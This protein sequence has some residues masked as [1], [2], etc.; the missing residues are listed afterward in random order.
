MTHLVLLAALLPA[1]EPRPDPK[2]EAELSEEVRAEELEA[3][4]RRLASA[5][6]MGRKGP[7]AARASRL[8]ADH[9][10]NL[11]LEPAFADSY[12]QPIPWLATDAA[13]QEGSVAG[14]N[15]AAVLPGSDPTL[16]DEWIILSAHFDH[17]GMRGNEVF[18]GADDNASGVALLM[19]LAEQFALRKQRPKRTVMFVG[20]DLE[21]V[22]LQGSTHFATKPPRDIKRL[23]AAFTLDMVGRSMANV[24][25]E[26]VFV[27]GSETAP[28]L[29]T[30]IE[31]T[32]TGDG[33]KAGRMGADIIGTRSDYGPF[34]DRRIPFLFFSTGQHP[35]YHQTT[36]TP[37][38]VEYPKL[39]RI[40]NYV[41]RL[42]DGVADSADPPV[43]AE[44]QGD[45]D[46]EEVR[47]MHV[48]VDRVLKSPEK[49]PLTDQ[50]RT[51]ATKA[52]DQLAGYLKAGKITT[53]ERGWLAWTAKLL[54]ASVF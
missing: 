1:A 28:Q 37:E 53:D 7:G 43:W 9:F 27:L 39:A 36:D 10:K 17:L 49:Y 20:F 32:P 12:F 51:L 33:L 22:G 5:E 30:L 31:K 4:V 47:T 21:E 50:Q 44:K 8:L 18:A 48:I 6:F 54:L 52:R 11:K 35:D 29:R 38:K 13:H 26:Y 45:G 19:E 24:M 2:V 34:R 15:V 40:T 25:E 16:K 3:H 46:L 14:R 42:L 23:K 41:G